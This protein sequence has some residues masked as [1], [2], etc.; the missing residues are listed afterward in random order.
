MGSQTM[1]STTSEETSL[2]YE[3]ERKGLNE[4]LMPEAPAREIT[5]GLKNADNLQ[6]E[7]VDLLAV[8]LGAPARRVLM[9]AE[10][11]GPRTGWKDGY[12][13]SAFGFL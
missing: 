6:P 12:L 11:V 13:S 5:N 3:Q 8:A 4:M 7:D 1:Y 10:E 9:R 2:L